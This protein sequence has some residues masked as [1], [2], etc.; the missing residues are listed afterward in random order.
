VRQGAGL[1]VWGRSS[2]GV[3]ECMLFKYAGSVGSVACCRGVGSVGHS[4][5]WECGWLSSSNVPS[6]AGPAQ[7][8]EEEGEEDDDDEE[9]SEEEAEGEGEEAGASGAGGQLPRRLGRALVLVPW[10]GC[11]HDPAAL[12]PAPGAP[13]LSTSH[14][15]SHTCL[16]LARAAGKKRKRGDEPPA[17]GAGDE[18]DEEEDD[19]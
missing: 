4:R 9:S 10:R 5:R 7:D 12:H 14:F 8:Y 17:A 19:E 1:G 16:L 13:T 18:E 11:A 6:W 15:T 3:R 2:R